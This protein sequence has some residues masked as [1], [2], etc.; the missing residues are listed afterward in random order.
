M[1]IGISGKINSGKDTIGAIIRYLT[2]YNDLGYT[3]PISANDMSDWIKRS[4]QVHSNWEIR[5]FADK[6]KDI[7]CLLIGCTRDQLEDINFKNKEL[8]EEWT[9]YYFKGAYKGMSIYGK[10]I[11]PIF[12]T[13]NEAYSYKDSNKEFSL[14]LSEA[15][16]TKEILTPRKLLQLIGTECGRQIIHP[17]IWINTLFADYKSNYNCNYCSREVTIT[18]HYY[19]SSC[20]MCKK[21][22][23]EEIYPNWIITDVRFPNELDAI[24]ERGGIVIRVN[25]NT[26]IND[27][28]ANPI[29]SNK[30][31]SNINT[32]QHPSE[33]ALDNATFDYIIDNNGT[34]D[35][36]I[37]EVKRIL[38]KEKIIK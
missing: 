4:S 9:V 24:K 21:G 31:Y 26:V 1:I 28:E 22:N 37:I 19:D 35:D 32:V 6:L 7:V 23:T 15:I 25:R 36:L 13:S 8:G 5:K 18:E 38:L 2:L 33:T 14:S 34:I 30:S 3:H 16:V 12:L 20:V 27:N 29:K 11:S 17:N 10:R